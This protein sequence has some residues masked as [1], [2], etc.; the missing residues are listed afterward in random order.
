MHPRHERQAQNEALFRAVNEQIAALDRKLAS[1][2]ADAD[3]L[4]DFEC[5]CGRHERC[6]GRIRMTLAE[7]DAVR[8][9]DDRF[10]VAPGHETDALEHVVEQ[11]ERYSIVDKI[12]AAEPFVRDDPRGAPSK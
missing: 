8:A 7:Y 3:E 2:S 6:D 10:L 9:Q 1:S 12:P 11:T 4:Y 5:E